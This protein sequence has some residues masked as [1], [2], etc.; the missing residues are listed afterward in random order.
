MK[1]AIMRAPDVSYWVKRQLESLPFTDDTLKDIENLLHFVEA[2]STNPALTINAFLL[3]YPLQQC[4]WPKG[5]IELALELSERDPLDALNDVELLA[6][7]I[8]KEI[9]G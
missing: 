9:N 8:A 7:T 6:N 2:R 4:R 5:M 1:A 3:A